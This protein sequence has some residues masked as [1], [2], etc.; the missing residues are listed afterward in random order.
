MATEQHESFPQKEETKK[1]VNLPPVLPRGGFFHPSWAEFPPRVLPTTFVFFHAPVK[2]TGPPGRVF[3]INLI[4]VFSKHK[5]KILFFF[6]F[7]FL[8][9]L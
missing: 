3:W 1:R 5:P 2:T 8:G 7:R 6:F 9:R 4:P